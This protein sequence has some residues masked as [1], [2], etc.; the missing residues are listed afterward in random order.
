MVKNAFIYLALRVILVLSLFPHRGSLS[1]LF[2]GYFVSGDQA[3]E[4]FALCLR[5]CQRTGRNF[6][7]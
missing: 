7:R 3:A 5:A 4:Q 6:T 2:L 1:N